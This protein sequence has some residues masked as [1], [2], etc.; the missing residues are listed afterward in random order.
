MVGE[1]KYGVPRQLSTGN[2][3]TSALWC[4]MSGSYF[5]PGIG[6]YGS[7]P[8]TKANPKD[9]IARSDMMGVPGAPGRFVL[10]LQL[11]QAANRSKVP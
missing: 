4:G 6:N 8:D 3:L 5:V 11:W 10:A 9:R 2:A 7:S 1:G